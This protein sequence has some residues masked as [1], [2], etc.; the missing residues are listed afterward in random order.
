MRLTR[1]ST[2]SAPTISRVTKSL[3]FSLVNGREWTTVFDQVEPGQG[4]QKNKYPPLLSNIFRVEP[5]YRM[6]FPILIEATTI[7]NVVFT[8]G[9]HSTTGAICMKISRLRVCLLFIYIY[10]HLFVTSVK[11]SF[12]LSWNE[13]RILVFIYF[14]QQLVP[15]VRIFHLNRY[16]VGCQYIYMAI[17]KVFYSKQ[18][19]HPNTFSLRFWVTNLDSTDP[20]HFVGS[21][22]DLI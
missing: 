6:A 13:A 5:G 8:K 1:C 11:I 14:L 20:Q 17:W 7:L 16:A 4:Q 3:H 18:K 22:S 2:P 15:P 9:I 12:L 21:G 10:K 19:I